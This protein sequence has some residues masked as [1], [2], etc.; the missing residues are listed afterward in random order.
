[1]RGSRVVVDRCAHVLGE[2]PFLLTP[3]AHGIVAHEALARASLWI[4]A[5]LLLLLYLVSFSDDGCLLVAALPACLGHAPATLLRG[6]KLSP[7]IRGS[8][9]HRLLFLGQ[10]FFLHDFV[11][12]ALWDEE[13][14]LAPLLDGLEGLEL[15]LIHL[16]ALLAL[17]PEVQGLWCIC[18][19]VVEG[20]IDRVVVG[21][22]PVFLQRGVQ[23]N[24]AETC[25]TA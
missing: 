11:G 5:H 15:L 14:L 7:W 1:M 17:I 16:E 21:A 9:T 10:V 4:P 23:A 3:L 19:A 25:A 24:G 2:G 22:G 6:E 20:S 8:K 18:V 12:G 13:R